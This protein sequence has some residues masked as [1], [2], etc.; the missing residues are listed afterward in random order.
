MLWKSET[1]GANL[2]LKAPTGSGKTTMVAQFL[3]DLTG[4]PRFTNADIAFLWITKGSLAR[5]SKDKLFEYYDGASENKLLDM[6]NLR[7]G[8]LP[9]NAVFFI[10]WEKLVSK[11]ADNRKLRTDGDTTTSFDTYIDNT[12][13]KG[14]EI[15]LIID[16]EHLAA[17][18]VLASDLIQNVIKPRIII[19]ISAT[20]QNVGAMTVE[21]PREDVVESGLLKEKSSSKLKKTYITLLV[22]KPTKTRYCWN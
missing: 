21:V 5:Q 3:R 16:E 6:N 11:S 17:N 7:D 14:R 22:L 2:I 13:A 9:R 4:E 10:N 20:P 19:G 1:K 8:V 18:T 15:V 12:R